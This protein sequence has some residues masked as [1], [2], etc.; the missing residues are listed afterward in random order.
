MKKLLE[1]STGSLFITE[2]VVAFH[3]QCTVLVAEGDNPVL[4]QLSE[5][6]K[7]YVVELIREDGTKM[8]T[9]G[10]KPVG[11]CPVFGQ[12]NP[13]PFR[14]RKL[15]ENEAE[16]LRAAQT[17]ELQRRQTKEA[18]DTHCQAVSDL[19]S[20]HSLVEQQTTKRL[21]SVKKPRSHEIF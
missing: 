15:A 12:M 19:Y 6:R 4:Q 5:R 13:L 7:Y 9:I 16:K 8:G 10:Y 1:T 20:Q 2:K 14:T 21:Q 11:S 18:R 17:K 3:P